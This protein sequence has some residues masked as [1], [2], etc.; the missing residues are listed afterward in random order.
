MFPSYFSVVLSKNDVLRQLTAQQE[1]FARH[2]VS[3]VEA[4]IKEANSLADTYLGNEAKRRALS[5]LLRRISSAV[6]RVRFTNLFL[7]QD[8]SGQFVFSV[9]GIADTRDDLLVFVQALRDAPEFDSV[10]SPISNL[11]SDKDARFKLEI[12]IK[13]GYYVENP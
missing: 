12:V 13:R 2:D 11:L 1:V 4:M 9:S 8:D 7:Q 10:R 6:A 5:P 3:G